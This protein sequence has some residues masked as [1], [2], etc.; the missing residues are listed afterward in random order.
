[1]ESVAETTGVGKTLGPRTDFA[2]PPTKAGRLAQAGAASSGGARTFTQLVDAVVPGW[3]I[4]EADY[5]SH[6]AWGLLATETD[7]YVAV[8]SH[9]P[10]RGLVRLQV[11]LESLRGIPA[12]LLPV[13]FR[14]EE[15]VWLVRII[16]DAENASVIVMVSSPCPEGTPVAAVLSVMIEELR[17]V[18]GDDRLSAALGTSAPTRLQGDAQ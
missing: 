18:L 13:I 12:H 14:I 1:M 15:R 16:H 6:V 9:D 4:F 5:E 17:T 3:D 11:R 2:T 8:L 7:G 10:N